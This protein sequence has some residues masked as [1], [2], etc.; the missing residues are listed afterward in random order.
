MLTPVPLLPLLAAEMSQLAAGSGVEG[1]HQ[2][3]M[4]RTAPQPVS[5]S[6]RYACTPNTSSRQQ[7][8]CVQQRFPNPTGVIR[9]IAPRIHLSP[10]LPP[11]LPY[12]MQHQQNLLTKAPVPLYFCSP[13]VLR[14]GMAVPVTLNLPVVP[15]MLR[16]ATVPVSL[17]PPAEG[18]C[19]AETAASDQAQP[20]GPVP[21]ADCSP[22][23]HRLLL[24]GLR[25]SVPQYNMEPGSPAVEST[26]THKCLQMTSFLSDES[27]E[28]VITPRETGNHEGLQFV[29]TQPSEPIPAAQQ[30][31]SQNKHISEGEP[32][33]CLS[34][35]QPVGMPTAH[36]SMKYGT[37][38]LETLTSEANDVTT[39]ETNQSGNG[40]DHTF[41]RTDVMVT[42]KQHKNSLQEDVN[43]GRENTS[44]DVKQSSL[45]AK[46]NPESGPGK[47]EGEHK[48]SSTTS[49]RVVYS[50]AEK[51]AGE[52]VPRKGGKVIVNIGGTTYFMSRKKWR[53]LHKRGYV[54]IQCLR[55][56][57]GI[58]LYE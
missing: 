25:S 44:T 51:T 9:P 26:E 13:L 42:P 40:S 29:P 36:K 53:L 11:G 49:N 35:E 8:F 27:N 7:S 39:R 17:T 12:T 58:G 55:D 15:V 14:E 32:A 18:V 45:V 24:C 1:T 47:A 31:P 48:I 4:S 6:K 20:D 56:P 23:T 46:D 50:A 41:T 2:A 19:I 3:K 22:S 5:L 37:S 16:P 34:A 57:T 28:I 54:L 21:V 43:G 38:S 30:F 33:T 10:R 52:S